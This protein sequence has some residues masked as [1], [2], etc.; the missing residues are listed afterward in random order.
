MAADDK[1]NVFVKLD[2]NA[3][4][5]AS[6]HLSRNETVQELIKMIKDKE[7]PQVADVFLIRGA[8]PM[9]VKNNNG[10]LCKLSDYD[11]YNNCTII[12]SLR[13]LGGAQ[14][15]TDE[16]VVFKSFDPM[17]VEKLGGTL[18]I[19]GKADDGSTMYKNCH[20]Y[21]S[22]GCTESGCPKATFGCPCVFCADCMGIHINNVL[23]AGSLKFRCA[24]SGCGHDDVR[25]LLLYTIAAYTD[26]EKSAA[27][28]QLSTNYFKRADSEM[29]ICANEKCKYVIYREKGNSTNKV[30]CTKCQKY[31]CW[32][33]TREHKGEVWCGWDDCD[34]VAMINQLIELGSLKTIGDKQ[35]WDTRFCPNPACAAVNGHHQNC[36]RVKCPMCN[37][38]YCH[39][40]LGLWNKPNGCGYNNKCEPAGK[41]VIN[42][43]DL[44][45]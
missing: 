16:G 30:Q 19:S 39:L 42:K 8:K 1:I 4:K 35:C 37:M 43:A 17:A 11:C 23:N 25:P 24:A 44:P 34:P 12:A 9:R 6:F 5:G 20:Y 22:D 2:M 41:Q 3:N 31:T 13:L 36:K 33:C 7:G 14:A 38:E 18:A 10:A 29:H 32:N 27:D 40:C 45:K 21:S 28:V 15:V 26:D